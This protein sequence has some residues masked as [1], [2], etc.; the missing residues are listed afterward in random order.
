VGLVVYGSTAR[1]VLPVTDGRARGTLRD[2]VESLQAEG[3]TNLEEGLV[4]GYRLARENYRPAA[5]N[6][7]V[8]ASDGIANV[9]NTAAEPILEQVREYAGK[10][11]AM[12]TA[13][14]GVSNNDPLMEQLADDG[15]GFYAYVDD[16][17]EGER[18]FVDR[19]TS[20][21]EMAALDAKVQ[22]EFDRET[23]RTYRLL[24]FENRQLRDREF[25]DDQR[26]AGDLGAGHS[27]TALYEV[28]LAS[29]EPAGR[30][31]EVRV[32]WLDP[33]TK[34]PTERAT[35]IE[36]PA[37]ASAWEQTPLGFR[38]ATV[39]AAFAEQLQERGEHGWGQLTELADQI[40][41]ASDDAEVHEL[42]RLVRL[43]AE[44]RR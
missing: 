40:A 38:V 26:D 5:N 23:V 34:E 9:G 19:L 8:L 12:V 27:V 44:G 2:A 6:R 42:A 31:G 11:I 3:S 28:E 41:R 13:G 32:R 1:V 14:F 18:L 29:S 7:V 36:L 21:L 17:Q 25:R 43:A 24:G 20:T 37:L 10:G 4:L 16:A 39:A 15:D 35:P 33:T 22:V 30:L